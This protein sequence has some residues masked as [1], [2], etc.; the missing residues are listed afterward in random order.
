MD[1]SHS[2]SPGPLS[3]CRKPVEAKCTGIEVGYKILFGLALG[4]RPKYHSDLPGP[5]TGLPPALIWKYG[6]GPLISSSL[7]PEKRSSSKK[8]AY[9]DLPAKYRKSENQR[10]IVFFFF[11]LENP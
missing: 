5:I 10:K 4:S 7:D 3:S 8:L 2:D 1:Q 9:D 11:F 6:K